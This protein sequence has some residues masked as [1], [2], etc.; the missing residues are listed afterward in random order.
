MFR[1]CADEI[2]DTDRRAY[3]GL[4]DR[5]PPS[6]SSANTPRL[7]IVGRSRA[8]EFEVVEQSEFRVSKVA[9][10][11]ATGK[12]IRGRGNWHF[13]EVGPTGVV[14]GKR[15]TYDEQLKQHT[16]TSFVYAPFLEDET[17]DW[18]I[19]ADVRILASAEKADILATISRLLELCL[20]NHSGKF[21]SN[22]SLRDL[23]TEDYEI[24]S[25]S[26]SPDGDFIVIAAADRDG[27]SIL[28]WRRNESGAC[29]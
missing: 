1:E 3:N 13:A 20:W 17:T 25:L 5:L 21:I 8:P 6:S 12:A 28:I 4:L 7:S 19:D 16:K 23:T 26:I 18:T 9:I 29:R 2:S 11:E 24:K 14:Y 10:L 22:R 27:F 15:E